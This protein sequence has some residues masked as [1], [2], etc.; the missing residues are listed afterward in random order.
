LFGGGSDF[1]DRQRL[2]DGRT[3][4]NEAN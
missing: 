4:T 1:S 2:A 3:L